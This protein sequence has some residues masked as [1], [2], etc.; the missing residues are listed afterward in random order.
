MVI[1]LSPIYA[2]PAVLAPTMVAAG[3]WLAEL[4]ARPGPRRYLVLD[5]VWRVLA[6]RGV[7]TWVRST[8]K[9]ARGLGAS[10][11]LITHTLGDFGAIGAAGSEAA[12]VSESLVADTATRAVMAQPETSIEHAR[13]TLGLTARECELLPKL[14]KGRALWH[15]GAERVALVHQLIPS[16]VLELTDTDQRMTGRR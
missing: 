8:M 13:S 15:L 10:V 14:A 16:A 7:A 3:V 1:D 11:V 4:L 2:S 12:R 6:D 5:E 9:L